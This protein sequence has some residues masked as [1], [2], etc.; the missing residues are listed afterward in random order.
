MKHGK[1]TLYCVIVDLWSGCMFGQE[2]DFK[3]NDLLVYTASAAGELSLL[4]LSNR[5][6]RHFTFYGGIILDKTSAKP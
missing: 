2:S 3:L 5:L 6:L 1:M 4:L